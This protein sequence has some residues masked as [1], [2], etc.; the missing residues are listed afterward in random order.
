MIWPETTK[1]R[2]GSFY[3]LEGAGEYPKGGTYIV[4]RYDKAQISGIL[5]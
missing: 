4:A 2:M 5:V 1:L 3:N